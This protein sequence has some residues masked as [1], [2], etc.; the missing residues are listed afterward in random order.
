M[1]KLKPRYTR[2][3]L[4]TQTTH[5]KVKK[6]IESN[7][8]AVN[9]SSG[10]LILVVRKDIPRMPFCMVNTCPAGGVLASQ[11]KQHIYTP[12]NANPLIHSRQ[13]D[14]KMCSAFNYK[15]ISNI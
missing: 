6:K 1:V 5:E 9:A 12:S 14:M 7:L 11:Y 8:T 4:L 13:G 2:S 15:N 10:G 3:I